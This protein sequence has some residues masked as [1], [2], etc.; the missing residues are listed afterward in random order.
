M[1]FALG[2]LDKNL[3]FGRIVMSPDLVVNHVVQ[4]KCAFKQ[5]TWKHSW[6]EIKIEDEMEAIKSNI[7]LCDAK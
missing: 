6:K 3:Q 2:K 7:K 5:A 4:R 1:N